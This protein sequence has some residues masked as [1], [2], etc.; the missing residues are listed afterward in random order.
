MGEQMFLFPDDAAL[1]QTD[2]D[3]VVRVA[4][5]RVTLDTVVGAFLEGATPETIADQY[6]S[7]TLAQVYMVIAYYLRHQGDVDTYLVS[8]RQKA[9]EV[10]QENEIRFD[11]TGVRS[12]L[13]ARRGS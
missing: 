6:P 12:R 2:A 3:G 11:P 13:L 10:R 1:L 8:R 5:T 9:A 4:R 7:L